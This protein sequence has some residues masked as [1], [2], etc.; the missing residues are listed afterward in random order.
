MDGT[1]LLFGSGLGNGDAHSMNNIGLLMAGNVGG[2]N[3][4]E[5]DADVSSGPHSRLLNTLR[6]EMGLPA[7]KFAGRSGGT[8]D[9]S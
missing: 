3:P 4:G 2:V 7:E 5:Y 6:D 9:L 1:C 8:M